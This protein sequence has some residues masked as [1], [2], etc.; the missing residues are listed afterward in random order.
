MVYE[1][2]DVD[3]IFYILMEFIEGCD[4]SCVFE[5]DVFSG[6]FLFFCIV[7]LIC[8]FCDLIEIFYYF[9]I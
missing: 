7:V 9:F 6:I 4:F 5:E 8:E 1:Y 3:D 2:G